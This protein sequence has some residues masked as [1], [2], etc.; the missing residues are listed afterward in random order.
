MA[1]KQ[2]SN[3]NANPSES[4]PDMDSLTR[5][6]NNFP[7]HETCIVELSNFHIPWSYP[8]GH[9]LNMP[10]PSSTLSLSTTLLSLSE[11]HQ[12]HLEEKKKKGQRDEKKVRACERKDSRTPQ[13]LPRPW[14]HH[15]W[16][17]KLRVNECS[18]PLD[19]VVKKQEVP[20][21]VLASTL[22]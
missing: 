4:C 6:P 13:A 19:L 18:S 7:N 1:T 16:Y 14:S 22:I 20:P 11:E 12:G 21:S 8:S 15:H 3:K 5:T 9:D 2:S 17:R 10:I